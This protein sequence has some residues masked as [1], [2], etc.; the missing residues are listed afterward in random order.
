MINKENYRNKFQEKKCCI[1]IPTYNN[2]GTLCNVID[3]ILKYTSQIIIVNDGSTDSTKQLLE[4]Y[5]VTKIFHF[6]Y[7]RG[8]GSAL[9]YGFKQA[10]KLGYHYA[11]TMDSD[12]QHFAE[13]IPCFIDNLDTNSNVLIIGSR[14]MDQNG[15]PKKSNFGRKFSNFWFWVETGI[16]MDDT[17]SG[18]RLYPLNPISKLRLFTNR[19][20]FEIEVIVRAAWSG[21]QFKSIPVKVKYFP[22]EERVSH[23]RPLQDFT[24]VSILNTILVAMALLYGRPKML[25]RKLN[26]K[27]IKEF[28]R[29]NFL[30]STESNLKLSLSVALG[31][32]VGIAP[33]W[34]Y[35]MVTAL[36]LAYI[37]KLNKI[38]AL[39]ASNISIPPMIPFILSL[40]IITGELILGVEDSVFRFS[41]E[42][43][44]EFVKT[45]L[46]VYI[47]GSLSIGLILSVLFGI[48]TYILLMLFR[49]KMVYSL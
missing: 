11:I 23:F 31:I 36:F 43:N 38:V 22:E 21:V 17:Q 3:A 1:I 49:K 2:S 20:E 44:F 9:N 45:N 27:N 18:F 24:R 46:L 14:N 19:F 47:V 48:I 30:D 15:I 7:N 40:S 28:I 37:F 35:Q 5:K 29:R 32:F 26:K 42:I 12:G 16:K 41:S 13:D 25:L 39:T 33:I 8:K 34:G 6:S 4:N 10:L